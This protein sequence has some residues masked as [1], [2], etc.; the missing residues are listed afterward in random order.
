MRQAVGT[1]GEDK[2]REGASTER[3]ACSDPREAGSQ[4]DAKHEAAAAKRCVKYRWYLLRQV[5]R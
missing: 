4:N 5:R 1:D 2:E 3:C